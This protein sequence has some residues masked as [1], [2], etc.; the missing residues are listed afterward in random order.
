AGNLAYAVEARRG[1]ARVLT[2]A[3]VAAAPAIVDVRLQIEAPL[4]ADRA[5]AAARRRAGRAASTGGAARRRC[6]R[7]A[8]GSGHRGTR[9]SL[10]GRVYAPASSA[11]LS[12]FAIG[13]VGAFAAEPRP[14]VRG[15]A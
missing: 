12:A 5:A 13:V 14:L 8:T 11:D 6:G 7:S 2:R 4:R 10:T 1:V 15:G 3:R 9:P